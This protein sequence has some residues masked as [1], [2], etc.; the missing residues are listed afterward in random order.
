[1]R[2][3]LDDMIAS[4]LNFRDDRKAKGK[5]LS[6]QRFVTIIFIFLAISIVF[7]F[8]VS[9]LGVLL[10]GVFSVTVAEY[11]GHYMWKHPERI[12]RFKNRFKF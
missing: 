4:Y 2:T 1:M 12:K 6:V 5:Q 3:P 8:P 11:I 9:V 10:Q 7:G